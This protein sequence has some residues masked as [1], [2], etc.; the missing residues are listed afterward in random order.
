[1][2][3]VQILYIILGASIVV[4][5]VTIVWLANEAIGLIKSIRR[6]SENTEVVTH[7]LK[8]KAMMVSEALDR[9][10]SAA[11]TMIGLIEDG[12]EA[13]KGKRDHVVNSIALVA[14]TGKHISK[15]EESKEE[16][17]K[18]VEELAQEEPEGKKNKKNES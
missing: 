16:S 3:V 5:T 18:E 2:S 1:M 15:K 17:K 4:L 13:I 10:G 8:D 11:S 12:T 6:S 14:G 7:E 9:V